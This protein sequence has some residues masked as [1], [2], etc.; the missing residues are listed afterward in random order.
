VALREKIAGSGRAPARFENVYRTA[1][2]F[3]ENPQ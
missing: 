2:D 3:L 1:F